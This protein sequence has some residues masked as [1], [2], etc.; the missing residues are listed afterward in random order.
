MLKRVQHDRKVLCHPEFISGSDDWILK[1]VQNDRSKGKMK[2]G[3]VYI[4][5]NFNRTVF[6]IG[7]TSD[8]DAECINIEKE[9]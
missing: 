9:K 1:Q 4:M 2:A 7:V 6:Y 5:S 8:L 3:F